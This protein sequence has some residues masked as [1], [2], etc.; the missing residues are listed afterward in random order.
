MIWPQHTG[1]S[2]TK[3]DAQVPQTRTGC[4]NMFAETLLLSLQTKH[5]GLVRFPYKFVG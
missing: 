3:D 2:A 1:D 5:T 4:L